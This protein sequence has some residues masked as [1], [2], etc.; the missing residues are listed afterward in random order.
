[1]R[2]A[3]IHY[4]LRPG[5]VTKVIQN[6]LKALE[7]SSLQFIVFSSEA[8]SSAMPVSNYALVDALAYVQPSKTYPSARDVLKELQQKARDM[9]GG[10]PDIWHIH[11]HALGKNVIV[12]ELTALLAQEGQHLL[13]Q[14]H[15]FAED[16]RPENYM[17]LR[18]HFGNAQQLG[19]HLYPQG[20]HIHYALL[21]QR[22]FQFLR[23]AG[24]LREQ[25]HYLPN[26]LETE[27][28]LPGDL[29]QRPDVSGKLYLYPGRAIRR[30]NIG[31]FL[32]WS[33]LA[34]EDELFT[35]SRAPK[36][37]AARPVYD[38]WVAFAQSMNLPVKFDFTDQ[39][40]GDFDSLLA[41]AHA[42]VTTS[43]AEGFGLAFLEPWLAG[44]PLLGRNL[45]EVTAA[46]EETDVNLSALYARLDIPLA[47]IGEDQFR[48][49]ITLSLKQ[50][51]QTYGRTASVEDIDRAVAAAIHEKTVDFGKLDESFQKIVIQHLVN[52]PAAKQEIHP[53]T[54][55]ASE[56]D[57][58]TIRQN[59]QAVLEHFNLD[60]YGKR[61]IQI[62]Q[63]VA[64]SK[65]E[66]LDNIN[67]DVLLDQFLA[68]ERFCLLRT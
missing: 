63:T 36:N 18:E 37:P 23:A 49:K 55:C 39:W 44:R 67:T 62:Y 46:I 43:L 17:L 50:V 64:D 9:L 53:L 48:Q 25:L 29:P 65:P 42:L 16:G 12:P 32:L 3:I 57:L 61:L 33:A 34:Q 19:A 60:T 59:R 26:A 10:L 1:M 11:N 66:P 41:A 52:V 68:P 15:D 28:F 14:S 30:K 35:I 7:K 40:Q 47:W 45:P 6:S 27:N 8:P 38:S 24:V 20:R 58:S 5:G 56:P 51:Y 21:N 54:L 4:H 13:L 2:I 22:D 31:E